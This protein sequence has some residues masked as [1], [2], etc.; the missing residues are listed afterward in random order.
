MSL[1]VRPVGSVEYTADAGETDATPP[2]SPEKVSG[3]EHTPPT[4]KR[5]RSFD[6]DCQRTTEDDRSQLTPPKPKSFSIPSPIPFTTPEGD[7]MIGRVALPCFGEVTPPTPPR[8]RTNTSTTGSLRTSP[9]SPGVASRRAAAG[10]L[11]S[12]TLVS[13]AQMRFAS[14]EG[15]MGLG[16]GP[17]SAGFEGMEGLSPGAQTGPGM[18]FRM[19]LGLHAEQSDSGGR[20]PTQNDP[21]ENVFESPPRPSTL[22]SPLL[23]SN[24]TSNRNR[25]LSLSPGSHVHGLASPE[26]VK[27]PPSLRGSKILDKLNLSTSPQLSPS[28]SGSPSRPSYTNDPPSPLVRSS[29]FNHSTAGPLTPL[30]PSR[31]PGAPLLSSGGSTFEWSSYS[32]PDS[33]GCPIQP[34]QSVF[35]EPDVSP[36]QPFF[37][38]DGR[39]GLGRQIP[40]SPLYERARGAGSFFP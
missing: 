28:L 40:V 37:M 3:S 6:S 30:T 4:T 5:L 13:L 38:P 19:A 34:V 14:Q 15:G 23:R 10:K 22:T 35:L 9:E 32:M 25:L 26:M 2:Q 1:C 11:G 7:K 31:I 33:P 17:G 29:A 39:V 24:S 20:T 16:V 12:L 27:I 21:S 36:R 8:T 18:A